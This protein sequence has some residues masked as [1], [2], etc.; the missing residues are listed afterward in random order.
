MKQKKKK[1]T[2]NK[3]IKQLFVKSSWIFSKSEKQPAVLI[4]FF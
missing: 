2:N 4:T 1:Q 3:K